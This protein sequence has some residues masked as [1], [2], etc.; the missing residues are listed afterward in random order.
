LVGENNDYL[1]RNCVALNESISGDSNIGRVAGIIE[2]TSELVN[3]YASTALDGTWSDVGLTGCDG[4]DISPAGAENT[5][6]WWK[7]TGNW[8]DGA[9][10][11]VNVWE[12]DDDIN[13]PVFKKNP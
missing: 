1:L 8:A 12:W 4:E 7:E 2:G 3:N 6:S 9:W 11:F 10:D 13:L 5:D